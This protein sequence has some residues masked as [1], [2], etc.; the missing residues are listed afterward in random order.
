MEISS[1]ED[2]KSAYQLERRS[3]WDKV[4][5]KISS[6]WHGWGEGYQKRLEQIFRF[7]IPEGQTVLELGC[8]QGD[9]LATLKPSYGVGVDFSEIMIQN[10]KQKHP[11]LHFIL[12]DASEFE[13]STQF[14]YIIFSDLVNDLWDVQ[15]VFEH[16]SKV[17]K[18]RTRVIVNSY[19]R[20]WQPIISFAEKI[21]LAKPNLP[22]NWLVVDDIKNLL[23]LAGFEPLQSWSEI[24][25]PIDIPAIEPFFNR[26]LVKLPPFHWLALTNF[27]IARPK[28]EVTKKNPKVSVVIPARNE[29]GNIAKVFSRVPRIGS[30]TEL[31]FVEGHSKDNTFETIQNE[32]MSHPEWE[33][34]IHQQSGVGKG[35]A[36]RTGFEHA[37]GDILMILDADLTVP[38]EDLEKFYQALVSGKGDFINGVRL[39]YPIEDNAMQFFN[40]LG[41]KFFSIAFSWLL[42]QSIKDTLC[43]TKVCWKDDYSLIAA[44]RQYFGNFDPFGDYD[45]LFGAARFHLKIVDLPV[46]YRERTYGT[47]NIQ[48]WKHGWM[49]IKMVG[50]AARKLKFI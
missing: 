11:N 35:D 10:A 40:L 46:R 24:L 44:N 50:F 32:V 37:T 9:L 36:V 29:A 42:G 8:G 1:A 38:P 41:N 22:Q 39:V 14:D 43:G 33:C 2:F 25:L 19:S 3:H 20:F 7:L 18:P 15:F 5:A 48:R 17:C 49:L 34:Q 27:I 16:L 30:G 26:F 6:G 28:E 4:G 21:G 13:S 47:T 45:L 31:I 12:A 23:N